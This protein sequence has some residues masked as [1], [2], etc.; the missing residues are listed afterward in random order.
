MIQNVQCFGSLCNVCSLAKVRT[1][2]VILAMDPSA[3]ITKFQFATIVIHNFNLATEP[4][5]TDSILYHFLQ[6]STLTGI[7]Y[8]TE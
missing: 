5:K 3:E 2:T 8:T 1:L 4:V 7:Q 6:E